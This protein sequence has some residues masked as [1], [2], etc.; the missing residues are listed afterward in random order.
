MATRNANTTDV[1]RIYRGYSTRQQYKQLKINHAIETERLKR[2]ADYEASE[3]LKDEQEK[4]LQKERREVKGT[5]FQN[6]KIQK[7]SKIVSSI[8]DC[9]YR[10]NY[11]YEFILLLLSFL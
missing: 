10:Q 7:C 9:N 3:R 5:R 8:I 2:I 11:F 6:S 4:S 1:Q